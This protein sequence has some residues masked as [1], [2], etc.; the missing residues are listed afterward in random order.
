M[1]TSQ[2][3][4]GLGSLAYTNQ[5]LSQGQALL[6]N[7]STTPAPAA[8]SGNQVGQ[9][10]T[11]SG[12]TPGGHTT[13]ES[14]YL[15]ADGSL[16]GTPPGSQPGN[17]P[18]SAPITAPTSTPPVNTNQPSPTTVNATPYTS[19][20]QPAVESASQAQANLAA[21]GLTGSALAAAQKSLSAYEQGHAAANVSGAPAPQ[22]AATGMS[23]A[24]TAAGNATQTYT[25]AAPVV[26]SLADATKKYIDDFANAMSS[27][28]QGKTLVQQYQDFTS[29]L[30]IPALNTELM[31]M[32]NVIN[33][34]ETD[35]RN[36]VTKA[37]GFATDSQVLAM[38]NA[39]NKTMIQNY[40]DLLQTR[41][42][43]MQQVN[44]M[45]GLA[46]QD[47]QYASAQIDRQLN[48]D[49]AQITFQQKAL[50]N[51]QS[52]IQKS[53]DT[54]GAASVLK[55]A[56]A[57]GDPTAV[58]RINATMGN[59]FDLQTAAA[60]PTLDEQVKQANIAQSYAAIRASNAAAAKDYAAINGT[61]ASDPATVLAW[62]QN[63]RSGTAK[64]SDIT[65]SPALKSAVS[66]ALSQGGSSQS[67]ILATTQGSIKELQDMVDKNKG[68]SGIGGAVGLTASLTGAG[69]IPGT[70]GADFNAK[71][72][73][74]KN[75]V[76]LPNLT[77]LHG[78]GRVTDREFQALTSAVTALSPNESPGQ[79]KTDLKTI[80]DQI[81]AKAAAQP[82][83]NTPAPQPLLAPA[84]IPSGYYQ[85][86]DGLLYKK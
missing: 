75:D 24:T 86:S 25:P 30:G 44:T 70:P 42:D 50:D 28:G 52:S 21:G 9:Y 16:S 69:K 83:L 65:G 36:E 40:N 68:F 72:N 6:S 76:I 58:A 12:T 5:L 14:G 7:K 67:D 56:L 85:A 80:S 78:L 79:F 11:T 13:T 39:R 64:L 33:G 53:I 3:T 48:F 60:H 73:Q 46:E 15:N 35:I 29:Q 47:R 26:Q 37:G 27:Q 71:L 31:N 20:S 82:A 77:L 74:V 19:T 49:Q 81:A 55:Q 66:L 41:S 2:P 63:I 23:A 62:A 61:G 22:D 18:S 54:Y 34:T 57:T 32:K 8:S 1:A 59:G 84:A 10:V 17:T 4:T 51:A 38:T 45:M 43:A